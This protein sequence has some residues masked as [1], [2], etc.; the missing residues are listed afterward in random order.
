MNGGISERAVQKKL[1]F[2][3]VLGY[4]SVRLALPLSLGR[5]PFSCPPGLIGGRHL[6]D[7]DQPKSTGVA[8]Q[9][10]AGQSRR[11]INDLV[12]IFGTAG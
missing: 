1:T 10:I 4:I 3:Q 11:R 2:Q 9:S 6:L 12:M 7:T 8:A 5:R